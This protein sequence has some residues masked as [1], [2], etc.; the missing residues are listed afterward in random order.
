M[1]FTEKDAAE[2]LKCSTGWLRKMR[3]YGGGP[4]YV[5]IGRMVRYRQEDLAEFVVANRVGGDR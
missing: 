5:K 1:M 3:L 2:Y 4:P